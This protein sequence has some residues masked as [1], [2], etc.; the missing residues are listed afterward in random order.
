MVARAIQT[1][2][3]GKDFTFSQN[4][5][6]KGASNMGLLTGTEVAAK[7]I[8]RAFR[9]EGAMKYGRLIGTVLTVGMLA[10]AALAASPTKGDMDFCNMKA[11]QVSKASP[12]QPGA[13]AT[14]QPAPSSTPPG[15]PVSPGTTAQPA[16]GTG[17][18]QPGSNPSGGRI[19]DSSPPGIP[20]SQLGMDSIGETDQRYRQ[21]YLA[22]IAD[23][24]K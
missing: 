18:P 16:P 22:C 10:G 6:P 13:A 5:C 3:P 15:T 14:R 12:V 17:S 19:T 23:R 11:A 1:F 24:T 4:P 20:P 7:G 8:V 21:T 9:K 2:L